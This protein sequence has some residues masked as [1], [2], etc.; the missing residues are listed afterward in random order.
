MKKF[1]M[2][3]VAIFISAGA[4]AQTC[5]ANCPIRACCM[6]AKAMVQT[7]A[8]QASM[9]VVA[10]AQADAQGNVAAAPASVVCPNRPN[11][12]CRGGQAVARVAPV[13]AVKAEGV[14]PCPNRPNCVCH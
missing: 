8:R 11:C 6:D 9:P 10:V 1:M 5:G 3:L 13:V 14:T 4:F 7:D 2:V 12:V